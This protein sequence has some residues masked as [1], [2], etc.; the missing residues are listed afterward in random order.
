MGLFSRKQPASVG[1]FAAPAAP[2]PVFAQP[3]AE[4]VPPQDLNTIT[5]EVL[6]EMSDG[7]IS[8]LDMLLAHEQANFDR[9]LEDFE[10]LP[11]T[12][13]AESMHRHAMVMRTHQAKSAHSEVKG[14]INFERVMRGRIAVP[15]IE[16]R[17]VGHNPT[18][19]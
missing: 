12:T 7:E 14:A 4:W 3:D 2:E 16:P 17:R 11:D 5:P 6:I 9:M 19:S 13:R 18:R 15:G 10:R 1:R 8:A